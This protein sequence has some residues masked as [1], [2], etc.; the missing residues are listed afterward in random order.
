MPNDRA[1][2]RKSKYYL[3]TETFL[4]ALHYC[5]QYPL[6][7]AELELDLDAR[8]G[9][10]YDGDQAQ[11]SVD[12]DSTAEIGMKRA[13]ISTKV[14]L[15]EDVARQIAGNDY[16]WLVVGVCYDMPYYQLRQRGIPYGKNI[17][18]NWRRRMI[19]EIAQKI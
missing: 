12:Y 18:Y 15:V 16:R 11:S 10:S 14:D 7:I 8:K 9:L 2:S 4:T 6:W 3:P 5:R 13:A 19:Y 17:Y 1:P